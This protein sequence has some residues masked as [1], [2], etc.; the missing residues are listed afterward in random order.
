M[1]AR[2]SGATVQP[3]TSPRSRGARAVVL[4]GVL[5]LAVG[6]GFPN[7]AVAGTTQ[8][9]WRLAAWLT[10]AAVFAAHIVLEHSRLRSAPRRT[11]VHAAAAVA[12]GA[13]GLAAAANVHAISTR[14]GNQRLLALA[15]VLWP[16][17]TGVPAF[18]A[19][20][21]AAA[22]LTRLHGPHEPLSPRV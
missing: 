9:A 22:V 19:A 3:G 4:F 18:V 16:L 6:M 14:T 5:Y 11:A 8:F 13:L 2:P 10:S 12:L 7:P 21:G 1:S 15:L 17:M 20:L